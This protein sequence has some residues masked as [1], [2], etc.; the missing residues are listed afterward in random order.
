MSVLDDG[1]VPSAEV[2]PAGSSAGLVAGIGAG[3]A[4]ATRAS[5]TAK[6]ADVFIVG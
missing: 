3:A 1:V 4:F 6:R 5:R 2:V